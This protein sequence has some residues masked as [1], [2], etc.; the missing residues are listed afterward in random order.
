M[1][2]AQEPIRIKFNFLC[3]ASE[4]PPDMACRAVL[5]KGVRQLAEETVLA[6]AKKRGGKNG[7]A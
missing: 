3:P 1:T 5:G 7:E 6:E 4:L 2:K